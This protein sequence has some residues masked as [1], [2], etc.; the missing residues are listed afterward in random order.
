M[1]FKLR[2]HLTFANVI[3]MIALFVALSG[4]SYAVSKVG[5]KDI[6]K[7]AVRGK[8]IKRNQITTGDIRNG[9][10]RAGDGT[11]SIN[12]PGPIGDGV[13]EILLGHCSPPDVGYESMEP[14]EPNTPSDLAQP[15][16]FAAVFRISRSSSARNSAR[17]RTPSR[18]RASEPPSSRSTTQTAPSSPAT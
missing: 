1:L 15:C 18:A 10:V 3:A 6:R 5:A 13:H 4:T 2:S 7:N 14:R 17:R 11:D 12:N 8:H 9:T 16:R